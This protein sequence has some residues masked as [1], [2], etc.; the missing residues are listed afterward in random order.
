ME[1]E[2]RHIEPVVEIEVLLPGVPVFHVRQYAGFPDLY[3]THDEG[4]LH[5]LFPVRDLN[6]RP[7]AWHGDFPPLAALIETAFPE[8]WLDGAAA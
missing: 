8:L 7:Q 4:L 3:L 1:R 5:S 2:I 6:T